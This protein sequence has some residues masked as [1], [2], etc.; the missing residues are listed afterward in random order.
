M[1]KVENKKFL[2]LIADSRPAQQEAIMA[3]EDLVV[4]SAG[5][6]TGKTETLARRYA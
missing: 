1:K 3:D 5:A 4:V 6:G 2:E